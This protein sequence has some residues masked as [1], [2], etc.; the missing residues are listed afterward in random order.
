MVNHSKLRDISSVV[1]FSS[2]GR[3]GISRPEKGSGSR[4]TYG[5]GTKA[6]PSAKGA[7]GHAEAGCMVKNGII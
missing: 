3:I 2:S 6:V 4:K 7:V 1:A 5:A